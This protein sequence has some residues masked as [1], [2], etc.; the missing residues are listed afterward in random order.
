MSVGIWVCVCGW[1]CGCVG[2]WVWVWGYGCVGVEVKQESSP[3]INSNTTLGDIV[4]DW[5]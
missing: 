4:I 2:I 1:V 3:V 5:Q